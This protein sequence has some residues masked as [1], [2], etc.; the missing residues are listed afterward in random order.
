M[1]PYPQHVQ[2]QAANPG[3]LSREALS[4]FRNAVW[5]YYRSSGRRLPWR[6]TADP[7]RILVS[8]FMLQQTQIE[9][10][11]GKYVSFLLEFPGFKDLAEADLH[12]VL[13][14]WQG[15]GY[16]RRAMALKGTAGRVVTDH[17]GALP[18]SM[19]ALVG[20]PGI[21]QSTAGA[22]LAFAFRI[23]APFI[24]TNIRRVF[25]HFFF[26][27]RDKV[28]DSEILPLVEQA[29]EREDPR[30]WYYALMDYGAMLKKK[31]PNPNRKSAHYARQAPFEGS[32]RQ[33]RGRLLKTILAQGP[34]PAEKLATGMGKDRLRLYRILGD[35]VREG[36]LVQSGKVVSVALK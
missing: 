22:V 16:N 10:V 8:E 11:L 32:D 4:S 23:P 20:L 29:L 36:F 35:L 5:D 9:R 15:L 25:I 19:D 21:G 30:H 27:G 33:I 13:R 3:Y 1:T 18:Q 17:G 7:Y 24:E 2:Q 14:A 26:S 6:E 12:S 31:M 28:R 34:M